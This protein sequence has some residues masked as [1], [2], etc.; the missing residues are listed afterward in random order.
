MTRPSDDQSARQR[1]GRGQRPITQKRRRIFL[2]ELAAHGS[3]AEAARVASPHAKHPLGPASSFRDL[4]NRDP[5]FKAL[6]DEALETADGHL[7]REAWRRAV[8]GYSRPVFQNGRQVG[9]EL[10]FSDTVLLKLLSCRIAR[11]MDRS[12]L[13]LSG[14]VNSTLV[15]LTITL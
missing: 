3:W 13:E 9:S 14:H 12:K 2:R 5:D 7:E 1:P 6:C 10:V 11:Y 15:G 4:A 8:E